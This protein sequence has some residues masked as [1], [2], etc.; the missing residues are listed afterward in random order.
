[1]VLLSEVASNKDSLMD[2]HNLGLIFAPHLFKSKQ[3][4]SATN[5]CLGNATMSDQLDD[6][7]TY[8][9]FLVD[10]SETLFQVCTY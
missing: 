9:S 8:T 5:L 1:M 2:S 6:I 4:D 3:M 10:N 7:V